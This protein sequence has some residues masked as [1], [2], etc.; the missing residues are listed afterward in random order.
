M[1]QHRIGEK[2]SWKWA[3]GRGEGKVKE[4]FTSRV[5]RKISG[6]EI[7]RN[8]SDDNP[9]YLIEQADG[10]KVLKSASELD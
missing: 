7:T 10:D 3:N 5:T 6:S 4:R 2:V 1:A 8:A 9:A